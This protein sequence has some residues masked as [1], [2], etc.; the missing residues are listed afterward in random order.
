MFYFGLATS[1]SLLTE[2]PPLGMG[3]AVVLHFILVKLGLYPVT[4]NIYVSEALAGSV[5]SLIWLDKIKNIP[6]WRRICGILLLCALPFVWDYPL[7]F[8][9][10]IF[11]NAMVF[12]RSISISKAIIEVFLFNTQFLFQSSLM[13]TTIT[14]GV[15]L[16]LI[17]LTKIQSRDI[18]EYVPFWIR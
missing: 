16:I 5:V 6:V 3:T 14:L 1:L 15:S 11:Y 9:F 8:M 2:L 17:G 18:D 7:G 13:K 10:V 12:D 4:S